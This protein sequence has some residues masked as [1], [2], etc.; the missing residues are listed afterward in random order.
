[1]RSAPSPYILL[2]PRAPKLNAV[3][4]VGSHES[5]VKG[6]NH[7]P[8]PVSHV[9]IAADIVSFLDWSSHYW[10][11]SSFSS[12]CKLKLFSTLKTLSACCQACICV[13][14][15]HSTRAGIS[16]WP[17][18]TSMFFCLAHLRSVQIPLDAFPSLQHGYYTP[19]L[20]ITKS[21]NH[22][23]WERPPRWLSQTIHLLP[24]FSLFSLH[25]D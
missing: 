17:F 25:M 16:A 5:G 9:S 3:L 7:L 24:I 19:Q 18:C 12:T 15:S 1:M 13:W 22:Q 2:V 11:V 23:G 8:H 21:Q 14:A 6:E 4:Q 20:G 10:L